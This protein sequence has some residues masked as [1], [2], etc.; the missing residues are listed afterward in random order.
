MLWEPL[1]HPFKPHTWQELG[2][3]RAGVGKLL[4]KCHKY[5]SIFPEIAEPLHALL[6]TISS[7]CEKL[8]AL[9]FALGKCPTQIH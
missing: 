9:V 7:P 4:G 5:L 8:F 3:R 2:E 6:A 1:L